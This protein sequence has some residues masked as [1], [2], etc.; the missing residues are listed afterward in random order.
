MLVRLCSKS[1]KLGF[2]STWMENLQA[3]FRKGRGTRHKI[4]NICWMVEKAMEFQKSTYFCLID[5]AKAYDCVYQ[6]KLWETLK[7]L[8]LPDHLTWETCMQDKKQQ[9]EPDMEQP[10]GSKLGKKYNRLYKHF[11]CISCETFHI[12]SCEMLGWKNYKLE[13]RLLDIQG[14]WFWGEVWPGVLIMRLVNI[15]TVFTAKSLNEIIKKVSTDRKQK[16]SKN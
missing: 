6:N 11:T 9:L 13:S 12:I 16:T 4:G 1:L 14:L 15:K 10:A 2:S 8:G 3:G 7:Q 5:Y